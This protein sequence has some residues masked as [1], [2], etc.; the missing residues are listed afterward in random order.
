MGTPDVLEHGAEPG[1]DLPDPLRRMSRLLPLLCA[2]VAG[3]VIGAT[4]QS[5]MQDTPAAPRLLATAGHDPAPLARHSGHSAT[6]ELHNIGDGA[7]TVLEAHV[8]A[9]GLTEVSI[10]V[11]TVSV[12]P[13]GIALVQIAFGECAGGETGSPALAVLVRGE[14]ARE[15]RLRVSLSDLLPALAAARQ[16]ACDAPVSG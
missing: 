7:V 13:G 16:F 6:V 10:D 2:V 8:V 12:A 9:S 4:V 14:D 11:P 1:S 15:H 3:G 5:T